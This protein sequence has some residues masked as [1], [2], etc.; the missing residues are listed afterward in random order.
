MLR[1][2]PALLV[3]LVLVGSCS[4]ASES[5]GGDDEALTFSNPVSDLG[6]DPYVVEDGDRYLLLEAR[7]SGELWLTASPPHNLTDLAWAG[8]RQKIW[9]PAPL[10]PACRDVWAPEI[11]PGEGTWFVYL[12]ATTCD[13]DNA[14]HR[15]F[16]LES[17]GEDPFGP[18]VERGQITDET[19]RWAIDGTVLRHRGAEYLVW[20]GWEGEVDGQQNLYVA[21]MDSPTSVT[22]S[23]VLLAEPTEDWE[24]HGMPVLE[25]PQVLEHEGAVHIVY[26]ASASWTDD[27]AYGLLT[28][29]GD[30][31]LDASS[32]TKADGPV[33]SKTDDVLG[34]GH[35]TFVRSPDGEEH[36]MI[37]HATR[38][39]GWDRMTFAQRFTWTDDGTPDF[40]EP[41]PAGEPQAV[42]S[43][44]V[45]V[46]RSP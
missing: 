28:L 15:L 36:W 2:V 27:Y 3:A 39:G 9:E 5:P 8:T 33:F 23:R 25:G 41:V 17:E 14:N 43:G 38:S 11:H 20:S 19:D 37:Y 6:N 26:S 40:G 4:T 10:G 16:V 44:Q 32:W 13:G 12:A 42:P 7:S 35:G 1:A 24:R 31:V 45:P 30:D 34:P 18:Y 29:T 46:R 21:E 22:G